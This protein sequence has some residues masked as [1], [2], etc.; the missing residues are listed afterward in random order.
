MVTGFTWGP[1]VRS[2]TANGNKTK[3]TEA[4]LTSARSIPTTD[5]GMRASVMAKAHVRIPTVQRT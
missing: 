5:N 1:A 2:T 4:E 3:N